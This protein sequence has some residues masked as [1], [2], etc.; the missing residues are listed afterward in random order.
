[1]YL[2]VGGLSYPVRLWEASLCKETRYFVLRIIEPILTKLKR[3]VA[4]RRAYGY[5]EEEIE[6]M[7]RWIETTNR[8]VMD[9][10]QFQFF[11]H[12]FREGARVA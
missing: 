4:Q 8:P 7:L 5:P 12:L 11:M 2:N 10:D 3:E 6:A 1:M 9:A